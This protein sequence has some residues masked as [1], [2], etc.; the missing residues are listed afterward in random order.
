MK[1]T[2]PVPQWI[3]LQSKYPGR[4]NKCRARINIGDDILWKSDIKGVKCSPECVNYK[5]PKVGAW[6]DST[7]AEF[8]DM[9]NQSDFYG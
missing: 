6:A 5:T 7:K 1:V 4:C 9:M 3:K 8:E 2:K